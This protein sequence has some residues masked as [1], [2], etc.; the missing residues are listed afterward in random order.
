MARNKDLPVEERRA[1]NRAYQQAARAR[2][3]AAAEK[4]PCACGCGTLIAAYTDSGTK[5]K[6]F[7]GHNAKSA[8]FK[9]AFQRRLPTRPK[10]SS[11]VLKE[12]SRRYSRNKKLRA[13][14]LAGE[15]CFDCGVRY[16]GTNACIFHHHHTDPSEKSPELIGQPITN[17]TGSKFIAE[18]AKCVILCANCHALRH[19]G[20]W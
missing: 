16:N 10:P 17:L 13:L 11:E 6:Y 20:G 15:M 8:A 7:R 12:R 1:K 9:K 3:R 2:K 14:K 4:V 19:G 18:L 5:V